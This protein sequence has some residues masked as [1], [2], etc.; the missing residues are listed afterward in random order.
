MKIKLL[1]LALLFICVHLCSS[2][3][4]AQGEIPAP[5]AQSSIARVLNFLATNQ[6]LLATNRHWTFVPYVSHADGLV[7]SQG[8]DAAWGGGVAALYPLNDYL[9]GGFRMQ[10]FA[11]EWFMPSVNV[12]LQSSYYLFGTKASWTPF[13]FTGLATPIK[14]SAENGDVAALYGI[15]LSVKVPITDRWAIGGGY[16]IENWSNL[17]VDHV[18]HFGL[19]LDYKF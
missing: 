7:D 3:A 16:A 4:R 19:V 15:G 8:K 2:V 17:R 12:Q 14:G 5:I 11:G 10:Y 1:F 13:V 18:D 6:E 9:R